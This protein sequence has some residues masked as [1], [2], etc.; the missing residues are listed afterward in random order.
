MKY[1]LWIAEDSTDSN[2]KSMDARISRLFALAILLIAS[3]GAKYRTANFIIDTPDPRMAQQFGEAA[4]QYRRELAASW[5]GEEMP[6]WAQPCPVTVMVGANLGA[7]GATTFV[8]DR[9]E[10]FG[11][12]MSIQGSQERVLDSVL[13]HEITHMVYASHFRQPLPRWADEGGATSVEHISERSKQRKML[14]QFLGSG[15]GIAFNQM[16]TMTE[17]PADVLPLYAQG[18]ALSEYLIQTGGR[19]KYIA[20][21]DDGLKSDDWTAAISRNYG[22]TDLGQLQTTW[23][24]WVK[25]GMPALAPSANVQLASATT[26]IAPQQQQ[27]APQT[28]LAYQQAQP[29]PTALPTADGRL[30]R[31]EPNL[32]LHV[33]AQAS[34][35]AVVQ[36][37]AAVP[38]EA[39]TSAGPMTPVTPA[40]QSVAM[41][42]APQQLQNAPVGESVY[43]V[44]SPISPAAA[45]SG[46]SASPA[47]SAVAVAPRPA[48]KPLKFL[49]P[50][51]AGTQSVASQP[52]QQ[53]AAQSSSAW[54]NA[55][56]KAVA[57]NGQYAS[58]AEVQTTQVSRPQA[59]VD[60][61]QMILR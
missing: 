28:A 5:L 41:N 8:F 48:S 12:R 9:G 2:G 26:P 36:A 45:G 7:G 58:S 51:I 39:P 54:R 33:P 61:Q 42:G 35:N 50:R 23:L 17:Y 53:A 30:A 27:P 56:E 46:N 37:S 22:I 43:A 14:Y 25:Q 32:I 21:L 40:A 20:F 38:V 16:F 18:Y 11:W 13:P 24:A 4:E 3:M 19:R 34:N 52:A 31:P 29:I 47:A 55:D 6:N 1:G 57:S 60:P 15:R 44:H 59:M 10:V 49:P